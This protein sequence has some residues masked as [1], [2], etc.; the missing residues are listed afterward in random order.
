MG[1][2]ERCVI[3]VDVRGCRR[4]TAAAVCPQRFSQGS[5]AGG[6]LQPPAVSLLG[7]WDCPLPVNNA[8]LKPNGSGPLSVD[9]DR[10]KKGP[11]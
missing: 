8:G 6:H 7:L 9:P 11:W 3:G 4:H 5:V 2:F 10:L 1:H